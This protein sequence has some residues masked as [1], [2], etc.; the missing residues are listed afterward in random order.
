MSEHL[1]D[2]LNLLSRTELEAAEM[3]LEHARLAG[4]ATSQVRVRSCESSL[5]GPFNSS[6]SVQTFLLNICPFS[7][8]FDL[9]LLRGAGDRIEE[10]AS[11]WATMSFPTPR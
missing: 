1:R 5:R 8:H 2:P 9:L 7:S 4:Q 11:E 10:G 6:L 3:V